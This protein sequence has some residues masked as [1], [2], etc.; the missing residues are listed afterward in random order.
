MAMLRFL[1]PLFSLLFGLYCV[2]WSVIASA[3]LTSMRAGAAFFGLF[4]L[5]L[6]VVYMRIILPHD[7]VG[8]RFS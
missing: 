2:I 8:E 6:S 3:S 5:A 1:V 7:Q 4:L